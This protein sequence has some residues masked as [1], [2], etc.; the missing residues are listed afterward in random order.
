MITRFLLCTTLLFPLLLSSQQTWTNYT[1]FNT[2]YDVF[3]DD[4][5]F[6]AGTQ[7][8]LTAT[9]IETNEN[10]AYLAGNSPIMGGGVT[11][12]AK[13]PDGTMWFGS[14]NAGI[15]EYKDGEWTNYYENIV[16]ESKPEIT[17]L[18]VLDNGGVLFFLDELGSPNNT[19][20]E[21]KDG[22]PKIHGDLPDRI[23]SFKA[24]DNDI[25]YI[26]ERQSI[27]KYSLEESDIIQKF[28]I[29]NS[30]IT[31]DDNL[32]NIQQD[33]NGDLIIPSTN[34]IFKLEDDE[35]SIIANKG[36]YILYSFYFVHLILLIK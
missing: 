26:V 29:G 21:L 34:H 28:T 36:H 10:T 25:V 8:G 24:I 13:A 23:N 16:T 2:I 19:L 18:E 9:N 1:T 33:K 11:S 17:N 6:W 22:T 30:V 14:Y 4:D 35:L 5:I 7:G 32:S 3:I 31:D 15:F 12:I 27:I 20:V